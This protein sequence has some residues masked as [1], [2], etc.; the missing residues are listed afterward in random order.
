MTTTTKKPNPNQ[1]QNKNKQKTQNMRAEQDTKPD[2]GT[3]KI[4]VIHRVNRG[5]P[6]EEKRNHTENSS[7]LT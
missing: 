4:S 3:L 7:N 5:D 6:T 2:K 1:Q